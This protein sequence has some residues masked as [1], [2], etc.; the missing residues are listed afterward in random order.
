MDLLAR[1]DLCWEMCCSPSTGSRFG[2]RM[3]FR[4]TLVRRRLARPWPR[5]YCG[6]ALRSRCQ[7]K[8]ASVRAVAANVASRKDSGASTLFDAAL[9]FVGERVRASTVQISDGR[10][11]AGSGVVWRTRGWIVTNAHVVRTPRAKINLPDGRK[12]DAELVAHDPEMD[13]AALR[14]DGLDLPIAEIGASTELRVGEL[15]IAVGC[16]YGL[17]GA[18]S[19]GIVHAVGPI[20][21]L[22]DRRWSR[23]IWSW[24]RETR[25]VRLPARAAA[26]SA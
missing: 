15:V 4:R 1:P 25:E 2:T 19:A 13:L 16:P 8:W 14:A 26:L 5:P 18:V 10:R 20:A 22:G 3:T 11:G 21:V 6:A 23:R 12:F 9:A 7:S 17:R 24:R